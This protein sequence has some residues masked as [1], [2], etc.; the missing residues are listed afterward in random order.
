MDF[1]K[2]R[3]IN[4]VDIAIIGCGTAG[5]TAAIYAVRAGRSAVVLEGGVCGGQIINAQEIANYPGLPGV[6]GYEFAESLRR[7]AVDQGAAIENRQATGLRR[8]DDF[9]TITTDGP[10]VSGRAV[11]IASGARYRP[12]GVAREQ[13]FIGRGLSY[14]ATCDG[15]FFR[16][17]EVAVVGGGN[18]AV[19][20]ALFLSGYCPAVYLIHR[21][22]AFRAEPAL[23]EALRAKSNVIFVTDSV[24]TALHGGEI[25]ETIELKNVHTGEATRLAIA[26]LF[27]AIGQVPATAPFS[28]P[29]ALDSYGYIVAGEDGQT[30]LPGLFAAGDCRAKTVHQLVTAASDGAV[31]ALGAVDYLKNL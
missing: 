2:E 9:W 23:M 27:V 18:T 13:E 5:L 31:A 30:G 26:G 8:E 24:V 4:M 1:C 7:Q 12:L 20:D 15:A 29:L 28:P 3:V 21:S 25:L 10:A 17:R 14:C 19:N 6:S 11:I 16:G 22:T